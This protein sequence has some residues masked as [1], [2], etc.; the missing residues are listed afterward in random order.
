[1]ELS[2]RLKKIRK[3]NGYTRDRLAQELGLSYGTITKYETGEREPGHGYIV[4]LAQKF[5]L[6][7]D[8][9]L[10]IEKPKLM[11]LP[12]PYSDAALEFARQFD[13]LDKW[14][15]A[16]VSAVIRE[17]IQRCTA[18]APDL[19]EIIELPHSLLSASAGT[20]QWLDD[21]TAD[22]WEVKLNEH[23]RKA[24]FA[25]DVAGDSMEPL[26]S[27]GDTVLVHAQPAINEGEVGL[28][29][30]RGDGYIKRQ[31]DGRLHSLNPEYPDIVPCDGEAIVCKGLVLG[32]LD[33][34]WIVSK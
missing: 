33:D 15:R 31:G 27:D 10:G 28:Y 22:I 29:V 14:G 8:Y 6:T 1:M 9:V 19:A 24:D 3:D 26:Y 34:A 18:P 25:V 12:L 30:Y 16:A 11:T 4:K 23:T 20:G 5:G 32:K 7:T 17:E 21:D 2:E 13:Q